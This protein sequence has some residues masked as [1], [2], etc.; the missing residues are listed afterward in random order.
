MWVHNDKL[1]LF[2]GKNLGG[3]LTDLWEYSIGTNKWSHIS[4]V[5]MTEVDLVLL[6]DPSYVMVPTDALN[7][8]IY[9][10]GGI[11]RRTRQAVLNH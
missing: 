6:N 2:G 8:D 7:Y 5:N 10:Y 4:Y 9:I 11:N 1:V 3:Y